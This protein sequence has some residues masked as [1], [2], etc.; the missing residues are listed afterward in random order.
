MKLTA[1]KAD[2]LNLVNGK[3]ADYNQRKAEDVAA[4]A[5]VAEGDDLT[6]ELLNKLPADDEELKDIRAAVAAEAAEAA[7]AAAAAAAEAAAKTAKYKKIA[8]ISLGVV[9][10]VAAGVLAFFNKDKVASFANKAMTTVVSLASKAMATVVSLANKYLPIAK[11]MAVVG[12]N[13]VV[14]FL[15]AS[16]RKA[17]SFVHAHPVAFDRAIT[18]GVTSVVTLGAR[19]AVANRDAIVRFTNEQCAKARAG[20]T[21][22]FTAVQNKIRR[23]NPK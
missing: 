15:S 9:G 5:N 3:I 20:L 8:L 4:L 18:A 1:D 14:S 12:Y 21:D 23:K 10:L 16:A 17:T 7:A 2:V 13:A 19:E 6:E 22:A 11:N